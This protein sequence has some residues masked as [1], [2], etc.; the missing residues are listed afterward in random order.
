MEM[1]AEIQLAGTT[2]VGIFH[3][4]E[5]VE[6]LAE[7]FLMMREGSVIDRGDGTKAAK[8]REPPRH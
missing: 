7:S 8:P 5:V 3:D 6:R 4:L 1:L 2:V